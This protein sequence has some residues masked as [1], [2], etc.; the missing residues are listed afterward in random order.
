MSKN[1][2]RIHLSS[3]YDPDTLVSYLETLR[4]FDTGT[5]EVTFEGDLFFDDIVTL[6]QRSIIFEGYIPERDLAGIMSRALF[7]AAKPGPL[8]EKSLL[9]E[10]SRGIRGFLK[11]PEKE[12]ILATSLSGFSIFRAPPG[13]N[14]E[15]EISGC[16]IFLARTLPEHLREG[17]ESAKERM[18]KYVFGE[19][20]D[21]VSSRRRYTA[22]WVST[23]GR[24]IHEAA[25]RALDAIDLRR[26]VWNFS[27]NRRQW[28]RNVN[29]RRRPVNRVI[30]GPVHSLHNLD[31]SLASE[32][33]WYEHDYVE[34]IP[35]DMLQQRWKGVEH[36]DGE[37]R[38]LLAT[39]AYRDKLEEFLRRYTRAL[40]TREWESAF[41]RLWGLLEDMTGTRPTDSHDITI[42]RAVFHY[43]AQNR[44][45]HKQIL[46]H[47]KNYRNA[48]VHA[49]EASEAIETYL[50]QL[51]RYVEDLLK[52]HLE[53]H[54][55][56]NPGFETFEE[57]V[58]FLSQPA[59]PAAARKK[60]SD[61]SREVQN[62]QLEIEAAEKA[63]SFHSPGEVQS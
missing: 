44:N 43:A 12:Y 46:N 17:H 45:L 9:G 8:Q 39:S 32:I 2:R 37:I 40:D 33:D 16:H 47:L 57:A 15:T 63:R 10:I 38:K 5:G 19:Y 28:K 29:E 18:H 21:P 23:R 41:V 11:T 51:K 54:P 50:Y 26:A 61:L 31:G 53:S 20:P 27:L 60:I 34:P 6:L 7:R 30:L 42:S 22:C 56:S 13:L 4:K 48:S 24:S 36:E 59:D 58:R 3:E 25:G 35:G 52:F 55:A 1:N 62:R 14:G 49:G